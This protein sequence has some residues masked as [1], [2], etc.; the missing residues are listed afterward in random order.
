MLSM[1]WIEKSKDS[2]RNSIVF[3]NK[4]VKALTSLKVFDSLDRETKGCFSNSLICRNNYKSF[5]GNS[6]AFDGLDG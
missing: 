4:S 5:L 1:A 3:G 6:Y 2:L